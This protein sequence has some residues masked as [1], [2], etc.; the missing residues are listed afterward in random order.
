MDC[1]ANL[2]PSLCKE[3]FTVFFHLENVCDCEQLLNKTTVAVMTKLAFFVTKRA[4][5]VSEVLVHGVSLGFTNVPIH[6][7]PF[8]P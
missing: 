3:R 8:C 5:C 6:F 1:E 7:W 4:V 2:T